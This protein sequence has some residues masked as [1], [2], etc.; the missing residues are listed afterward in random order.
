MQERTV[1]CL[2]RIDSRKAYVWPS[3]AP[4]EAFLAPDS[5]IYGVI[6]VAIL[7][8]GE[9]IHYCEAQ[10]IVKLQADYERS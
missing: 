6:S 10:Q 5:G 3:I 8:S 7:D 4:Q 1:I 2:R 9:K